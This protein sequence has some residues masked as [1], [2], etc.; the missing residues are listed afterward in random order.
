MTSRAAG[1]RSLGR[2]AALRILAMAAAI[3]AVR[4]LHP[5]SIRG[6]CLPREVMQRFP[7]A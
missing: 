6:A 4:A 2:S 3:A 7:G 1:I 5:I